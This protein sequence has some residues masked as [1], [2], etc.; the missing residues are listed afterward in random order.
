MFRMERTRGAMSFL[1]RASTL[2]LLLVTFLLTSCSESEVG[3]IVGRSY[4]CRVTKYAPDTGEKLLV[5]EAPSWKVVG[6]QVTVWTEN[7]E[8]YVLKAPFKF[9][10]YS[11][12]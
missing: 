1:K 11:T 9:E 12:Q 2:C 7:G 5:I 10:V 6:W 4:Q 3:R 8:K